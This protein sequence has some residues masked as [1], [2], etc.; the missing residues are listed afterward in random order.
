MDVSG[1][2]WTLESVFGNASGGL[3]GAGQPQ[4]SPA[5]RPADAILLH[6]VGDPPRQI[7]DPQSPP[8][9]PYWQGN[10]GG[11]TSS[12]VGR[13]SIELG[14][15]SDCQ[16]SSGSGESS[17]EYNDLIQFFNERF[18]FYNRKVTTFCLQT[19]DGSAQMG[20]QD[21]DADA[22]ATHSPPPFASALYRN[23]ASQYYVQQVGCV[24]HIVAV[25]YYILPRAKSYLDQCPGYI[26]EYLMD[27][28]T[29]S[30]N[31]GQ[32]ACARLAGGL[33]VHAAGN[34]N[35]VPPRALNSLPRKYG[36]IWEPVY[37]DEA[38]SAQP[39]LNALA[40]CGIKV[41]GADVLNDPVTD[42]AASALPENP[43]Q[44]DNAM[45]QLKNDGVT[46]VFC[47]CN[48]WTWGA[49]ARAADSQTYYPEWLASSYGGLDAGV[50]SEDLGGAPADQLAHEFGISLKPRE[51]PP[52][53]EPYYQAM[54]EVDPA[55][56]PKGPDSVDVEV[57]QEVY[58]DLLVLMSGFQMA[59]PD[60]TPR[61]MADGLDRTVFPNPDTALQA[62]HVGFAGYTYSMTVDGAEFWWGNNQVSPYPDTAGAVCYVDDGVRHASGQWPRG[63][64]PFFKPPCYGVT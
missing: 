51:I 18:E 38:G 56:V 55:V 15:P 6:C 11:A 47:L 48:L 22:M 2:P 8:C 14:L 46:S 1:R 54:K 26:Y 64:D 19:G 44:A 59:G 61:T 31:L 25:T 57:D 35:S 27:F 60:L 12:G 58:R 20:G 7:E 62:G 9:I 37:S 63:G 16:T 49:F 10:N 39:L 36:I 3:G 50:Y 21:T 45:L 23:G 29:E 34:D 5:G 41:S 30:A 13:D 4:P 28:D 53:Q 42:P 17:T 43:Y 24:H 52:D 32:W 40:V 33:A